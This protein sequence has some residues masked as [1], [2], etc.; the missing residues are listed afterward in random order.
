[1]F[2][3]V[4]AY[5]NEKQVR[6]EMVHEPYDSCHVQPFFFRSRFHKINCRTGKLGCFRFETV[7]P[8]DASPGFH[9]ILTVS[10]GLHRCN[11]TEV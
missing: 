1:L 10:T 5:P 7:E 11:C 8:E 3:A 4:P 2:P 6:A 9:F